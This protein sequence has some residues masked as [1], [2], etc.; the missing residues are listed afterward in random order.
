[1]TGGFEGKIF[2]NQEQQ[3]KYEYDRPH[4]KS[5]GVYY[6]KDAEGIDI[7]RVSYRYIGFSGPLQNMT[8]ESKKAS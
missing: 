8:N 6:E 4:Y 1:M 2:Y 3:D 7:K 5:I